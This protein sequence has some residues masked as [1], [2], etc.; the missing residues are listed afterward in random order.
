MSDYVLGID[1]NDY[2]KDVPL[3]DAKR[4]GVRF[5]INKATEGT[6]EGWHVVHSTL[7]QY[8]AES[9][10]LGLPFGAYH[11]WR[12]AHNAEK[13]AEFYLKHLGEVQFRPIIDVERTNNRRDG[14]GPLVS[15]QANLNHLKVVCDVVEDRSGVKPMIYTNWATWNELFANSA[16]FKDYELWVAS[17]R[18]GAPFMPVGFPTWKLW[19]FTSSYYIKDDNGYLA[20]PRGVDG[21]Y[22]NGNEGE[23]EAYLAEIDKLWHP[24]AP[25]PPP[26]AEKTFVFGSIVRAN[27]SEEL[28]VLIDGDEIRLR[29]S[30]IE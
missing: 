13:Q 25:P 20:Y 23:F 14:G 12:F 10:E 28:F 9:K 7:E 6:E 2:R 21:N 17:Y 11:Y 27:G 3:R 19:Q 15:V 26:P 5:V 29:V 4:R 24:D 1:L 8:R 16:A 18:S 22:F 30:K